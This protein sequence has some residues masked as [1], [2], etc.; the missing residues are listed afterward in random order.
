[1]HQVIHNAV[2]DIAAASPD[3][4]ALVDGQERV[5]YA[6]L[7]SAGD[8]YAALLQASG[9]RP[10]DVVPLVFPRSAQQ[11][12][13]SLGVL[14]CGASYTGVDHRWPWER[15]RQV[16]RAAGSAP[17]VGGGLERTWGQGDRREIPAESLAAAA[18]RTTTFAPVEVCP[19]EVATVFFTS[20]TS[21]PPKGVLTSHRAVT[22]LSGG[23]LPGFGPGHATPQ[24]APVPWDM[25]AFEVWGQLTSGGTSVIVR[26]DHLMPRVLRRLVRDERVGTVWLTTTLFN[27]FVDE[28]TGSFQGVTELYVGGEKQSPEHV[29]RF[30]R[31]H[32][33]IRIWNAY[34]PA[35]NCMLS[36]VHAMGAS[37]CDVPGGI[38][39]GRPVPGTRVVVLSEAGKEAASN[40]IGEICVSGAGLALGYL[41]DEATTNRSFVEIELDGER[42]RIYRTGDLG[43]IDGSGIVHY[44]GRAD[45]QV[46]LRGHRI[47]MG[48]IENAANR[49]PGIRNSAAV[50]VSGPDGYV[51]RLALFYTASESVPCTPAEVRAQLRAVLPRY[52][53]PATVQRVAALP[54]TANGKL[55]TTALVA[56]EAT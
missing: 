10:G 56:G 29:R 12:A 28:D 32:P 44:R 52:A 40:E 20:G 38:P 55:D 6:L 49:L 45:R 17:V 9:V 24:A 8:A 41:N 37:D 54:M 25:Y 22:R 43:C 31:E 16:V 30:V 21:G 48:E 51:Q 26:E 27:L 42:L 23:G 34:G 2:R 35:E 47:E 4:L 14:K 13:V 53:V 7:D 5:T 19:D 33:S 39:V 46:K 11:V 50:A 36:T 18:D 15:A 1:M 3:A